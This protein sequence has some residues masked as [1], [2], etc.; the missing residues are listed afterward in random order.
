M[1][2]VDLNS[3]VDDVEVEDFDEVEVIRFQIT[4]DTY[5]ESSVNTDIWISYSITDSGDEIVKELEYDISGN[6]NINNNLTISKEDIE[7]F[8][9]IKLNYLKDKV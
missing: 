5:I 8:N 9:S 4:D 2:T 3:M 1:D 7:E 6:A